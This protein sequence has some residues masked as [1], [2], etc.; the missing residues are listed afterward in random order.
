MKLIAV[1]AD[2]VDSR[3]I[4]DRKTVQN[5]LKRVLKD[6]SSNRSIVSPYTITLGDE[7]QVL[8]KSSRGLFTDIFQIMAKI[9]P[10]D[11]RFSIGLG[12]IT[13][14]IN[15]IE[16]L[17][18]DGPAFHVARDSLEILKKTKSLII[19]AEQEETL[20]VNIMNDVLSEFSNTIRSWPDSRFFIFAEILKG[21]SVEKIA[22]KSK[23]GERAVYKSIQQANL[24]NFATF[25]CKLENLLDEKIFGKEE[26]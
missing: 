18:M 25:F 8:Y 6:L 2:L 13:T 11:C 16:A 12:D 9:R 3:K 4:T 7:F 15:K 19:I 14:K 17:G 5:K 24:Q 22:K 1:I 23:L 21:E 10:V 20:V 26:L